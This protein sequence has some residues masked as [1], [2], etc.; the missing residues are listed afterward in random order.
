V[1]AASPGSRPYG[2]SIGSALL[3]AALLG[4]GSRHAQAFFTIAALSAGASALLALRL[5][6]APRPALGTPAA[7]AAADAG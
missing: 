1:P 2:G 5:G 4:G 6:G 3:L 7:A